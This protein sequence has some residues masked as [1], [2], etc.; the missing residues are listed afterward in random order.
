MR[1]HTDPIYQWLHVGCGSCF[2]HQNNGGSIDD[3]LP[4]KGADYEK[5]FPK[6]LA[7]AMFLNYIDCNVPWKVDEIDDDHMCMICYQ[8]MIEP[9]TIG[10]EEC[11]HIFCKLCLKQWYIPKHSIH[12]KEQENRYK[13]P[14][15]RA[16]IKSLQPAA[17]MMESMRKGIPSTI[18]QQTMEEKMSRYWRKF[19]N[20]EFERKRE[21]QMLNQD[22][23]TS[24]TDMSQA[25]QNAM[26]GY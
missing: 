13:C 25:Q 10:N 11:P 22:S 7:K 18:W 17:G 20:D 26:A 4:R 21:E 15:C 16:E 14:M 6:Q 1:K 24:F 5:E 2:L 8:L 12:I 9:T 3:I 19:E 23:A